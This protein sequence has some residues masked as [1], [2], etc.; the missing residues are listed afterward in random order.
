MIHK[1]TK[2]DTPNGS[3]ILFISDVHIGIQHDPALRLA[4]ECAERA[5]V[6]KVAA[7]GDIY[8]MNCLSKH[9]KE[10][11][12]VVEHSTILEEVESGRWFTNWLATRDT[13][14]ILGNH[15]DRLKRFVD[16]N[17]VFH[18]SVAANFADVVNLPKSIKVIPQ[19]GEIRLGN[20][21]M[22]HGDA[23]FKKSTGGKYPAHKLLEMIPDQSSICGH[24]H[25][26]GTAFRTS[27]D[28]DGIPR[29]RRAWTSG[30]MSHEEMHHGYVSKH[31]NWQMGFALIRVY[32]ESERP[33]WT[34]YQ[35]EVLFDRYNR[36][37]FEFESHIYR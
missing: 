26:M 34:V 8:D 23:E 14:L 10:A 37:Y 32:W 16:E 28:E 20:L 2:K 30:H 33:R 19:A 5:G 15:E 18:G 35:I 25:R 11:K 13:L 36:P 3:L 4:V 22:F 1:L 17:P 7:C 24:V 31:P 6:T 9:A 21:S 27:R 12:R 29:T